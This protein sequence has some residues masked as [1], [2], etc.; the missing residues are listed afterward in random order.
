[1][2]SHSL[3]QHRISDCQCLVSQD[4]QYYDIPD[5]HGTESTQLRARIPL[6]LEWNRLEMRVQGLSV[7]A[8]LLADSKLQAVGEGNWL[9]KKKR[10]RA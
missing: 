10:P 4:G 9:R 1:M 2:E 8:K 7:Y 5:E 6:Q 3:H